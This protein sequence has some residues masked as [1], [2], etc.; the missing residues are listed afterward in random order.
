MAQETGAGMQF[1]QVENEQFADIFGSNTAPQNN[2]NPFSIVS[3]E[4]EVDIFATPPAKTAET[5]TEG[6]TGQQQQQAEPKLDEN[7]NP[8][9]EEV[10]IL[11]TEGETEEEAARKAGRPPKYD[12]KDINGYFQDRI[13]SNKLIGLIGEDD[14]PIELKTPE[15]YDMV[16][17][18]NIKYQVE[19]HK[20]ELNDTW[21]SSKSAAWKAVAQ[22]SELVDD[23]TQIIPFIQGIQNIQSVSSVDEKTVEGAEQILRYYKKRS[24]TPDEIIDDEI[25]SLKTSDKLVSAAT[26]IKPAILQQETLQL[27]KM[28]QEAA[29]E[30]ANYWKMVEDYEK[31]ARQVIST[32][33][34]GAKLKPEE[35][36][37]IY[38]MIAVPQEELGGYAI[39]N[40]IDGLYQ[41]KDFETLRK[42]AFLLRKEDNF[43]KIASQREVTK[44]ANELQ[45]KVRLA[46]TPKTSSGELEDPSYTGTPKIRVSGNKT[47]GKA[48]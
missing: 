28:Q 34:F 38:N 8:I 24:G 17:D 32:P 16:I 41:K 44:V 27:Q 4:E 46:T 25:E 7:G 14:Q 5:T 3:T 39:Y 18:E 22:Y 9:E 6:D 26:K 10:D 15:D 19:Q 47:F 12:F 23:P 31:S 13:K 33:L 30:E 45:K 29:Q 1:S 11:G 20:K 40:E 37:E 48:M 2:Q 42:I 36:T 21:Y 43:L 35:Q